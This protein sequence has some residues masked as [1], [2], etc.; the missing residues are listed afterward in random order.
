MLHR[1]RLSL[2]GARKCAGV[3]AFRGM[4]GVSMTGTVHPSVCSRAVFLIGGYERNSAAG[5]FKRVGRELARFRTC[6]SV[7]VQMGRPVFDERMQ[8]ATASITYEAEDGVCRS[9]L[10]FLCF[11]DIVRRDGARPFFRRLWAYIIAFLDYVATG[12]MFRFFVTNWRFAL[13]FLYPMVT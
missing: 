7:D 12:T 9:E 10:S 3:A 11:D 6:W 1:A 4:V 8:V 5:F 2:A 13:Y